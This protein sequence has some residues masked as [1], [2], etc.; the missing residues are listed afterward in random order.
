MRSSLKVDFCKFYL[1]TSDRASIWVF[2]RAIGLAS[3]CQT[4]KTLL[5]I[6]FSSI[7]RLG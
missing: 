6:N 2:A 4:S 7:I 1:S 3:T 5:R